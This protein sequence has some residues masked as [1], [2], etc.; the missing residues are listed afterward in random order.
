LS[1]IAIAEGM[2]IPLSDKGSVPFEGQLK[3][4]ATMRRQGL[5]EAQRGVEGGYFLSD[6]GRKIYEEC[7]GL[8]R[9]DNDATCVQG[10]QGY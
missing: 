4:E 2:G 1:A 3:R 7:A 9:S 6:L 5:I 10:I 8:V